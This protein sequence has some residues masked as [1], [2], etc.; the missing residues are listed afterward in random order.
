MVHNNLHYNDI[1]ELTSL[2]ITASIG[3]LRN[4]APILAS[5][6]VPVFLG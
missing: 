4:L 5:L 6:E 1:W 3:Y 2:L